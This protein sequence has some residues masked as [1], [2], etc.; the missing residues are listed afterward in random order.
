MI[1]DKSGQQ[2]ATAYVVADYAYL[3]FTS[4]SISPPFR[5][6]SIRSIINF[7]SRLRSFTSMAVVQEDLSSSSLCFRSAWVRGDHPSRLSFSCSYSSSFFTIRSFRR[8]SRVLYSAFVTSPIT[9]KSL[10]RFTPSR[11][12]SSSRSFVCNRCSVG[13]SDS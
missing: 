11:R 2:R 4:I 7:M 12:D 10:R 8:S 3:N 1:S 13:M 5:L 9:N 6:Y